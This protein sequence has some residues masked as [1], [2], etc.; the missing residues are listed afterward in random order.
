MS[1]K[2]IIF[3]M[4]VYLK[5]GL[6]TWLFFQGTQLYLEFTE[7]D[8][9]DSCYNMLWLLSKLYTN[10]YI[11]S[12]KEAYGNARILVTFCVGT[13]FYFILFLMSLV[14]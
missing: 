5:P 1:G 8:L 12:K 10:I 3:Q 7:I 2:S 4:A 14:V 11:Q 9:S 13:T 6:Q